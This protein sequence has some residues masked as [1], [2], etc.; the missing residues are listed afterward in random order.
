M[1]KY[2]DWNIDGSATIIGPPSGH[3]MVDR[4]CSLDLQGESLE[5]W[6]GAYIVI[7]S[8]RDALFQP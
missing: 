5:P 4:N 1:S 3:E 7:V 8:K 2:V 6:D